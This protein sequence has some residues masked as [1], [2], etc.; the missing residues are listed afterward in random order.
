MWSSRLPLTADPFQ[1]R[2]FIDDSIV[3]MIAVVVVKN[4]P[5]V[6]VFDCL[7]LTPNGVGW[8]TFVL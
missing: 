5:T 8:K 7:I 6:S 4:T 2:T 3:M 1:N